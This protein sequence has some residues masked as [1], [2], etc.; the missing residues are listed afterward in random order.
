MYALLNKTS[1][2][3]EDAVALCACKRIQL[4]ISPVHADKLVVSNAVFRFQ[5]Y[6]L[7]Q[8]IAPSYQIFVIKKDVESSGINNRIYLT[9]GKHLIFHIFIDRKYKQIFDAL[10]I[11]ISL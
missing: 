7:I 6:T 9:A 3:E 10:H 11:K 1:S 4:T 2:H 8:E 5:T